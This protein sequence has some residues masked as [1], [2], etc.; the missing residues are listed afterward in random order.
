VMWL[1]V[2]RV[3]LRAV[4]RQAIEMG[5]QTTE[6]RRAR[7]ITGVGSKGRG[8]KEVRGFGLAKFLADRYARQFTEAI[9]VGLVS[10]RGLHR[11]AAACFAGVLAGYAL[12]ISVISDAARTHQIGLR[13]MAIMLPMLAITAA[14]GS[15]SYDDIALPQSM[16]GLPDADRLER[17]LLPP[18]DPRVAREDVAREGV[19]RE[20]VAPDGVAREDSGPLSADP[21]AVPR[22][23]GRFEGVRFRHAGAGAAAVDGNGQPPDVLAGVDLELAAG[24]ST[25]LV[26]VNGAGKSTLVSLLA[27][28]RDPTGGR[29]TVD[30]TD[31]RSMDPGKWQRMIALMPQDP[32]RYP[33]SAYDNVAFGAL[34]FADDRAGVEEC[35]RLSGFL[36]VVER[37]PHGWDSIL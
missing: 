15:V 24:T 36:E 12:A 6:M 8:G 37:L 20:G 22:E 16:F 29:I 18:P 5:G 11:R 23:A 35:A 25:A 3:M 21:A 26:G 28:L 2:R 31:V 17:D 27:R 33:L 10:L 7:Y 14:A 30:G 32:V 9:G 34:A 1:V 4:L 19:A 13:S